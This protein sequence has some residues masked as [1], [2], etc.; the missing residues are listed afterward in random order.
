VFHFAWFWHA[1]FPWNDAAPTASQ[2]RCCGVVSVWQAR[3]NDGRNCSVVGK[4]WKRR[5]TA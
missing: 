3:T 4:P 2:T 1:C 5:R